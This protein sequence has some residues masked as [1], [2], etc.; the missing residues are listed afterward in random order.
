MSHGIGN[1]R[2]RLALALLFF[3]LLHALLLS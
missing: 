2:R 1:E 3:L